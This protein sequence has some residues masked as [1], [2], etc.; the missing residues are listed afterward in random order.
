MI[1]DITLGQYFEG[2]SVLHKLDPRV[3]IILTVMLIV[4]IFVARSVS[5]FLLLT[6]LTVLLAA[7][8]RIPARILIKGLKPIIMI[9][10]FT[11][12]FNIFW[13]RGE[14]LLLD[15]G[16]AKIYL[17]GIFFAILIVLRIVILLLST[18]VILTYTTTPIALTDGI[19]QLLSPLK[20]LKFPVHEFSMMMTIALRFIPTL[21]EETDKIMNAQK[22]RGADFASGG[23]IRR[24]KNLV[25]IIVPLMLGAFRRAEELAV[26]ME[27]RCYRG[28][29]GR[30]RMTRLHCRPIDFVFLGVFVLVFCAVLFLNTHF[31]LYIM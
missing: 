9:I 12:V 10:A 19:E 8:S 14:T 20:K 18:T 28:G 5:S 3:K 27:T 16:F 13:H 4:V 29:E 1:R 17:E 23:L 7:M 11:S 6:A 15:I 26:A 21:I 24:A 25:P 31:A 30:T 22:A 2:D